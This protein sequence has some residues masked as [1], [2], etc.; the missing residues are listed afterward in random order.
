MR[1]Q[2]RPKINAPAGNGLDKGEDKQTLYQQDK[3]NQ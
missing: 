2:R 1:H 3:R